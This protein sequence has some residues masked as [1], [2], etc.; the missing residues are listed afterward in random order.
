[1]S[2]AFLLQTLASAAAIA[3]LV[4]FTAWAR[5][6]RPPPKLDAAGALRVLADE[7]PVASPATPWI[8]ADGAGAVARSG[9]EALLIFRLGDGLVARAAPWARVAASPVVA[10]RLTVRLDDPGAPR[11]RLLTGDGA[12]PFGE[13]PAS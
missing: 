3:I 7:F 4:G 5:I 9:D 10:G 1:M 12:S 2:W 11:I 6:S 13:G 8:A